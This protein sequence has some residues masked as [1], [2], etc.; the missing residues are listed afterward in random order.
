[1][2]EPERRRGPA[3]WKE[4]KFRPWPGERRV[5]PSSH[6]HGHAVSSAQVVPLSLKRNGSQGKPELNSVPGQFSESHGLENS[7]APET[8]V[9]EP[10][11]PLEPC[12]RLSCHLLY[13]REQVVIHF[14]PVYV[15]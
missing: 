3:L 8:C 13:I 15:F 9:P 5:C 7:V 11:S 6:A 1:M 14:F 12:M 10:S 4:A 2:V